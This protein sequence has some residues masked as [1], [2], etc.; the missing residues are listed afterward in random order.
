MPQGNE[1]TLKEAI[2]A[3]IKAYKY[4]DKLQ[5]IDIQNAWECAMGKLIAKYTHEVRFKNGQLFVTLTAPPLREELNY[6]KEEIKVLVNKE[7]GKDVVTE[8][9]IK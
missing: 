6:R 5:E 8:V 1:K 7:L 4:E 3:M 9:I 2:E